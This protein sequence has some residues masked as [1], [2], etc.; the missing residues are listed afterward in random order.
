MYIRT[1]TQI[2]TYIYIYLHS[3][4][5]INIDGDVVRVVF[6]QRRVQLSDGGGVEIY[7]TEP[8]GLPIVEVVPHKMTGGYVYKCIH[9]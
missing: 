7:R 3:H 8:F 1:Y 2:H 6:T 4:T 9:I 5:C